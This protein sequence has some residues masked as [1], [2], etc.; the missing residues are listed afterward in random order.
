MKPSDFRKANP[1]LSDRALAIAYAC[2][3][4]IDPDGAQARDAFERWDK[5][6]MGECLP[7]FVGID[8]ASTTGQKEPTQAD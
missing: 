3:E 6:L 1:Q 4:G 5:V 7:S 2:A 8:R